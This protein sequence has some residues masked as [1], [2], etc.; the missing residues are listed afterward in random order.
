MLHFLDCVSLC[1]CI[2]F[3]I[4]ANKMFAKFDPRKVSKPIESND[5]YDDDFD[6]CNFSTKSL[7]C[8]DVEHVNIVDDDVEHVNVVDDDDEDDSLHEKN[9]PNVDEDV[10]N[11]VP[12][13]HQRFDSLEAAENLFRAYAL[14]NGFAIKVQESQKRVGNKEIYARLFVCNLFG[15]NKEK[16]I[17][18]DEACFMS[19]GK[20]KRRRDVLPRCGCKVRMYVLN[21]KKTIF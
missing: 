4:M 14:K 19:Q 12:Y 11:V 8:D 5:F 1:V 21:K 6:V 17:V 16:N 13:L 10:D 3:S 9:V 2:C 18:N 7:H 20:G 15:E